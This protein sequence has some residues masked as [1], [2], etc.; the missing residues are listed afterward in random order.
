MPLKIGL[1]FRSHRRSF[2]G[3]SWRQ[4]KWRYEQKLDTRPPAEGT[5]AGRQSG[6]FYKYEVNKE[7]V[8]KTV[9]KYR[10]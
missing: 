9:G 4:K 6:P 1:V 5:M 7:S 3:V 10:F 2:L 8:Y